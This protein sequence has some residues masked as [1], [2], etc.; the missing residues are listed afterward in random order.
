MF[1]M[2]QDWVYMWSATPTFYTYW[3][4]AAA[5]ESRP[6]LFPLVDAFHYYD[7]KMITAYM[8]Q[9]QL[10]AFKQD[11][12]KFLDK[13][14]FQ[15]Y[16]SKFDQESAE[17]WGWIRQIEAKTYEKATSE[18]LARDHMKFGDYHRDAIAYFGSTR[19]EYTFAV[20]Q[21]LEAILEKHFGQDWP[22][23]FGTLT[24]PV[25]LDDIQREY[26]DWLKLVEEPNV[27]DD[28]LM[29]HVSIYPWLVF[30]QYQEAKVADHLRERMANEAQRY[31]DFVIELEASKTALKTQQA[32][33]IQAVGE[34]GEAAEYL[35]KFLQAQAVRRMDIKSFW[36]GGYYLARKLWV[37]S[38]EV[39]GIG[40][41]DLVMFLA[42]DEIQDLLLGG[43]KEDINEVLINRRQAFAIIFHLGDPLKVLNHPDAEMEFARRIKKYTGDIKGQAASLGTYVGRVRKVPAGDLDM[44]QAS[45]KEFQTG[46]VLVTSMTQPNMMVIARKAGAIVADEGGITSHA[47]IISRE[48]KIPC[49]VGCLHAMDTLDDGDVVE[50][51][52]DNG[53]VTLIK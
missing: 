40:I 21:K 52:A 28:Q 13:E 14:Y 32:E 43:F 47:A 10:E 49:I 42:P 16:S 22:S 31:G 34:D 2:Q 46:E 30:G 6:E 7:G 19:T 36:G 9:S 27:S 37:K 35:V 8:P 11:G 33:I 17:W 12:E 3:A 15:T 5:G 48:L 24:T 53:T 51:N 4:N 29:S 41:D 26:L 25:D 23:K 18:E 44:L 20:E 1:N 39:I 38:A 50:V 45:I